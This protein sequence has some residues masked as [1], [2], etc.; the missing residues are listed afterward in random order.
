MG[1]RTTVRGPD[2]PPY[3]IAHGMGTPVSDATT[4]VDNYSLHCFLYFIIYF[5]NYRKSDNFVLDIRLS[6]K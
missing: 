1:F 6:D 5:F 4:T 2:G 3:M